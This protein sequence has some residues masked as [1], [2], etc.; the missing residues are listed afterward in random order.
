MYDPVLDTFLAV[1]EQG[2]FSRAA[3]KLFI[4]PS[5]VIQ[6]INNLENKLQIQFF[7]RSPRGV[8]LT[9]AG[10]IFAEG[11][12]RVISESEHLM[13]ALQEQIRGG[14]QQRVVFGTN[15]FLLPRIMMS[16]W[17]GFVIDRPGVAMIS[18]TLPIELG[19]DSA[20]ADL[21]ESTAYVAEPWKERYR[22]VK[23]FDVPMT[24]AGSPKDPIFAALGPGTTIRPQDIEGRKVVVP[25]RGISAGSDAA[26]FLLHAAGAVCEEVEVYA[27]TLGVDMLA[28]QKLVLSNG[29]WSD[30]FPGTVQAFLPGGFTK[31]YGFYVAHE[32]GVLAVEFVDYMVKALEGK[33]YTDFFPRPLNLDWN[34][35]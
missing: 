22:F 15:Y 1:A 17:Q 6:Q 9:S 23:A 24:L 10:E 26:I 28:N 7:E 12:R 33:K 4:T 19:D 8:V 31:E 21:I 20:G 35:G 16:L 34:G 11:A 18:R 3:R 2:S 5:A 30:F 32:A 29:A 13:N 25:P 27:P 14:A